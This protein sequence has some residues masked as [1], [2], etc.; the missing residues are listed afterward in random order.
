MNKKFALLALPFFLLGCDTTEL[1]PG[2]AYIDTEF[3]NNRYNHYD[4]GM[5]KA[6]KTVVATLQNAEDG[7]F[8]GSGVC[9]EP[10]DCRGYN[11]AKQWHPD[12]FKNSQGADLRW[13]P[14]IENPGVGVWSDQSAL[15]DV[16]YSQTKKLGRLHNGFREG[17][18]SKL[19][20]GQVRCNAWGFYSLVCL[21][22]DGYGTLFP[23]ELLDGEYFA[24]ACRGGSNSPDGNVGR[25]SSF[26][27]N[28]TF[29]KYADDL[30]TL[31]GETVSLVDV[32]LQTNYSAEATSL[33]GFDF[34]DA[35]IDPSGI[36]GMS[37]DFACEDVYVDKEGEKHVSSTD[38]DSD[39]P[40]YIGLMLLEVLIP[41][42]SWN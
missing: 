2:D 25:V 16:V 12:Y 23:A 14:D 19:Y 39:S 36:V 18:L 20:N 42:S 41:D 35:N 5:L 31:V 15:Y 33:V 37:V 22:E 1:Y 17:Y 3:T 7:Y 27:I 38:F 8:N 6:N 28:V 13:E 21:D 40:Y 34:A 11:Q 32:K 10:S 30:E 24:F 29:Y 9:D 26:D 4:D